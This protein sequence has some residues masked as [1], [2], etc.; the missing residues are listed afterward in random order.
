V[1][2]ELPSQLLFGPGVEWR[3]ILFSDLWWA[4]TCRWSI[5]FPTLPS[6]LS[7]REATRNH[8]S[9]W[10]I[11]VPSHR[12]DSCVNCLDGVTWRDVVPRTASGTIWASL[13]SLE[14]S[15]TIC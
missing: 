10:H 6:Q 5:C 8:K 11:C 4:V 14:A 7:L 15:V 12:F 3:L 1:M 13:S 2:P 9:N